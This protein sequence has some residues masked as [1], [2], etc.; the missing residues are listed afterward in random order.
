MLALALVPTTAFCGPQQLWLTNIAGTGPNGD[1]PAPRRLAVDASGN[2]YITGQIDNGTGGFATDG[3]VS[4]VDPSGAIL[5]TT[6]YT[7]TNYPGSYSGASFKEAIV[8]AAGN[9]YAIGHDRTPVGQADIVVIKLD[10]TGAYSSSWADQG[11]GAGVR[12]IGSDTMFTE[13]HHIILDGTGVAISA[14]NN[15]QLLL[16]RLTS[17]GDFN[18]AWPVG[19][20]E[21][22]GVKTYTFDGATQNRFSYLASDTSGNFY[23]AGSTQQPVTGFDYTLL[24]INSAGVRQWL[25]TYSVNTTTNTDDFLS[26]FKVDAAGNCYLTGSSANATGTTSVI[27]TVKVSPAGAKLWAK[28]GTGDSFGSR[29]EVDA[30][31]NVYVT[32]NDSS[33]AGAGMVIWKLTSAGAASTTWPTTGS[34][35]GIRRLYYTLGSMS[36]SGRDLALSPGGELYVT[37]WTAGLLTTGRITA[38]NGTFVW[39]DTPG[40]PAGTQDEGWAVGLG[41]GGHL[42]VTGLKRVSGVPDHI[43]VIRYTP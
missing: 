26:D 16:I 37:G 22:E 42:V 25:Y 31:G 36:D 3:F 41:S 19:A 2:S 7:G 10:S 39:A 28:R 17:S 5:W 30:S 35:V 1:A 20:N 15:H 9:V 12:R 32:G 43:L 40:L 33:I 27:A 11:D 18:T 24:K 14:I 29:L 6:N 13:G 23:L 21:R 34:G 4:K 8:D 38:S